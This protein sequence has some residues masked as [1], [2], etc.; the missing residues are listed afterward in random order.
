MSITAILRVLKRLAT[1]ELVGTMVYRAQFAVYMLSTVVLTLVGLFIWT[2]IEAT[3]TELPIDR[4]FIVSYYLILAVVQVLVSAWHGDYLAMVIRNGELNAWLARPGSYILNLLGNNIAEK[5]VKIMVIVPM[6][7]IAW[8]AYQ[9]A[10]HL[11]VAPS[12]WVLFA[13]T[14]LGAAAI[15]FTLITI[16]GTLGFWLQDQAGVSRSIQLARTVLSGQLVPLAVFP[17]WTATFM[18]WQP[19]RYTLSFPIEV[20]IG[21]LS[22]S[23]LA[24]GFTLQAFWAAFFSWLTWFSW[25]RGL[26]AYSAVGA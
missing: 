22:R 24:V 26:R 25:Q 8:L 13:S 19:F 16:V 15:N 7:A 21:D 3:G 11:P 5:I 1:I 18:A 2:T 23:Q 4:Q 17:E 6:L 9:D 10:F 12:R 20:L 14:L